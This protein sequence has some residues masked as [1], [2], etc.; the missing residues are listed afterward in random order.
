MEF[1]K[2]VKKQ[3]LSFRVGRSGVVWKWGWLSFTI[4]IYDYNSQI[5]MLKNKKNNKDQQSKERN[6]RIL[7]IYSSHQ[8]VP[9]NVCKAT[10]LPLK[11]TGK[12]SV[13][14]VRGKGK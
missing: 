10:S 6:Q 2:G 13:I 4:N 14:N 8:L 5:Q 9:D 11:K 3:N 7:H 1:E 12:N